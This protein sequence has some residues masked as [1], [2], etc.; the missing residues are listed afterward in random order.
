[1]PELEAAK[2]IVVVE[3]RAAGK[4]FEKAM[5][6]YTGAIKAHPDR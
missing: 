2:G 5:D 6:T 3:P 1:M 4:E